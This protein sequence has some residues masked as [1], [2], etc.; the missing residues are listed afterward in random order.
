MILPLEPDNYG[1]DFESV[2]SKAEF[3]ALLEEA[4]TVDTV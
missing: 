3:V 1:A 4:T 2:A